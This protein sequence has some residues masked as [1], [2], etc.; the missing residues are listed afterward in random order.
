MIVTFDGIEA[1]DVVVV[2]S[3]TLT[4]VTPAHAAGL[5]SFTGTNGDTQY[6]TVSDGYT[7]LLDPFSPVLATSDIQPS[8]GSGGDGE[9]VPPPGGF[10]FID[11][12]GISHYYYDPIT[13]LANVPTFGSSLGGTP[14]IISGNNFS[15]TPS[16]TFDGISATDVV[17]IS[18]SLI[19][20]ITPAHAQALVDVSV[21]T[22]TREGTI[23]AGF[24]YYTPRPT[25]YQVTPDQGTTEGGTT[26]Q[27]DG[28]DFASTATVRIGGI[29]ATSITVTSQGSLTCTT[30]ANLKGE[31]LVT[32]RNS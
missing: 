24:I 22:A 8:G 14:V 4:C 13:G 18:S 2:N 29:P 11:D 6:G 16:V 1:T 21:S 15:G 9:G 31:A 20:C 30:P 32:V 23:V 3:T 26:I 19:S 17:L 25:V 27:I 12:D 7:Y 10:P 5:V 28:T